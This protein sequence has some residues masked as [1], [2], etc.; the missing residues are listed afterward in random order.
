MWTEPLFVGFFVLITLLILLKK[1]DANHDGVLEEEEFK[2]FISQLFQRHEMKK[3]FQKLV[4]IKLL[5]EFTKLSYF[6]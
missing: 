1:A 3:I 6:S 5:L 4:S 2:Y